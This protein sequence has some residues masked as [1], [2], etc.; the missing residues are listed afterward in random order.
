MISLRVSKI[1]A[2]SDFI[3]INPKMAF[4]EGNISRTISHIGLKFDK[5]QIIPDKK[6]SGIDVKRK[7][8][9]ELS[10]FLKNTE[11][12]I[13]IKMLERINGVISV[14]S[15]AKLADCPYPNHLG[16]MPSI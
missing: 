4:D 3:F 5:G 13:P 10:R 8:I 2:P 6:S 14:I 12:V 9:I 15:P 16:T 11:R 7:S 1:V